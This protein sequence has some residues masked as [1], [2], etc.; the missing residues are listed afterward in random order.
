LMP[1]TTGWMG[2]NHFAPLPVAIY[3]VDLLM[4]AIA[5]FI[6]VHSLIATHGYDSEFA[7]RVG[8]DWKGKI[9][10]VAYAA[11]IG[12]AFVSVWIS[13]ALYAG[14]AAMWFIPDRRFER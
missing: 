9:P 2:E 14:V 12:L 10:L 8:S 4:C 13:L 6:L 3:G 11:G 7:S 1:F 5:Y